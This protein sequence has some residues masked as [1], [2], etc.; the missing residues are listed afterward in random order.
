[1]LLVLDVTTMS[2]VTI[3]SNVTTVSDMTTVSDVSRVSL[4]CQV[5]HF[6]TGHSSSPVQL[7]P[8]DKV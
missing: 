3:I 8:G 4:L 5:D 6:L 7:Q 1:M 2:Y